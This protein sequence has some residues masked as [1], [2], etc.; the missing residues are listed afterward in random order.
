MFK[1]TT[2]KLATALF[3]LAL[4]ALITGCSEDVQGPRSTAAT[5]V[6]PVP[7][8]ILPL[9][10]APSEADLNGDGVVDASDIAAFAATLSAEL[11]GDRAVDGRD[12]ALLGAVL[13]RTP[14]DHNGDG[15]V[16]ASDIAAYAH[17]MGSAAL[18]GGGEV[19]AAD[20]AAFAAMLQR[21]ATSTGTTL[22]AAP[23]WRRS[24]SIWV[25]IAA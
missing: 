25:K 16:D 2:P 14:I 8:E 9:Q 24:A 23:T 12:K 4:A 21:G 20:V 13:D 1:Q 17:A 18:A 22:S 7:P 15:L 3:V 6:Q 5:N 10:Y 19:D 11:D